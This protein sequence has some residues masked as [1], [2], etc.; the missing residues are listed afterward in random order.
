MDEE[1]DIL[2]KKG[3]SVYDIR[4]ELWDSLDSLHTQNVGDILTFMNLVCDSHYKNLIAIRIYGN[5]VPTKKYILK[6]I[7]E[8]KDLAKKINISVD[9]DFKSME[10]LNAILKKAN[11]HFVEAHDKDDNKFYKVKLAPL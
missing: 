11:F 6:I 2:N 4:K 1:I 3:K 7:K 8:N 9:V 5:N 10:F